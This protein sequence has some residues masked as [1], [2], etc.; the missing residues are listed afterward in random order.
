M[1][2]V[3]VMVWFALAPTWNTADPNVPSSRFCPLNWVLM[4][5]RC[6]SAT[7]ELDS[8]CSAARSLV[9]L[10]A[11]GA[12]A[13]QA[14]VRAQLSFVLEG[15]LCQSLLPRATGHG[16]CLALE[17][18]VPN[19][20]IRN[21]I[22]EDKVHQ[23]YSAMQTGQEKYGMQTFNQALVDLVKAVQLPT[24]EVKAKGGVKLGALEAGIRYK[25]RKDVMLAILPAGAIIAGVLTKSKTAS[26]PV[27]WCRERLKGRKA[28]AL[29]F[30]GPPGLGVHLPAHA[31]AVCSRH[32]GPPGRRLRQ[33]RL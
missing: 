22:R 8:A 17:I 2:V 6:N 28:R 30:S 27:E 12:A 20:A 19:S 24:L 21:L 14:Q 18:L 33:R 4:A 16:R 10:V 31:G 5:T 11:L 26:A 25:C 1:A 32:P 7:S 13:Q 23:I 9:L 15:I 29:A 3:A